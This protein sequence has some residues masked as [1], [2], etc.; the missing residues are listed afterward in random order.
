MGILYTAPEPLCVAMP[1]LLRDAAPFT[2]RD[3][4]L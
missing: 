2:V 3:G 1:A 4:V